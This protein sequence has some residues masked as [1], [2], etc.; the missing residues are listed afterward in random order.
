MVVTL[1]ISFLIANDCCATHR[2][3]DELQAKQVCSIRLMDT[4]YEVQ[5]YVLTED[6]QDSRNYLFALL[7]AV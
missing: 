2:A 7:D 4:V 6:L 5:Q 3:A 1:R